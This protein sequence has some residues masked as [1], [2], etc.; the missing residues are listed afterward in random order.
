MAIGAS[1]ITFKNVTIQ[2]EKYVV[3]KEDDK[4]K[5]AIVT[6]GSQRVKRLNN[7][8][9]PPIDQ[10]IMNPTAEVVALRSSNT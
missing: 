3:V 10:A 9:T 2:S 8:G 6:T 1:S 7:H 4:K 5:I